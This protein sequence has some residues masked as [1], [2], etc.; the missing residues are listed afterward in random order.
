MQGCSRYGPAARLAAEEWRQAGRP[1]ISAVQ[2]SQ[3]ATLAAC[4]MRRDHS[5]GAGLGRQHVEL[6]NL[7]EAAHPGLGAQW[8]P[9]P[10]AGQAVHSRGHCAPCHGMRPCPPRV[11]RPAA[12]S[13]RPPAEP[14]ST[15][16]A[17]RP[18][19]ASHLLQQGRVAQHGWVGCQCGIKGGVSGDQ[20]R[21]GPAGAAQQVQQ[22]RLRH[23]QSLR[24]KRCK[25][26]QAMS[27]HGASTL[28]APQA[29]RDAYQ[30][31]GVTPHRAWAA[32]L[33][34]PSSRTPRFGGGLMQQH[35]QTT[36]PCRPAPA[37]RPPR[38]QEAGGAQLEQQ[39]RG[40]GAAGAAPARDLAEA[41]AEN[42]LSQVGLQCEDE[43]ARGNGEGGEEGGLRGQAGR[44]A[45][46]QEVQQAPS[47]ERRR[48]WPGA[49][50]AWRRPARPTLPPCVPA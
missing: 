42:Q 48:G 15:A 38:L 6:E 13:R 10:H 37:P 39:R 34:H 17:S 23:I 14:A 22:G 47:A 16:R 12:A 30:G 41:V 43:G 21:A 27:A 49:P 32:P 1:T 7:H 4:M 40:V 3:P 35:A 26:F 8:I 9:K 44:Q 20:Q 31:A 19:S 18:G 46:K 45:G 24:G 5:P 2:R 50:P 11:R 28:G 36:P 33:M 25:A 29:R